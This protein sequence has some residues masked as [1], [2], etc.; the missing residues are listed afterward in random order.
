MRVL[1][2]TG[3]VVALINRS[4]QYHRSAREIFRELRTHRAALE[5]PRIA[6]VECFGHATRAQGR[7][8]IPDEARSRRRDFVERI[9]RYHWVVVE[10]AIED[11]DTD[12]NWWKRFADWPIDFPDALIAASSRRLKADH[13]WTYDQ[14]FVRFLSHHVPDVRPIRPLFRRADS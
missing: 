6:W 8:I 14:S 2:D 11:F 3:A 4:D 10:H 1:L 7:D 13:V 5:L 12:S 9:E